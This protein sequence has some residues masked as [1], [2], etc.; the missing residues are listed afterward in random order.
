MK[1]FSLFILLISSPWSISSQNSGGGFHFSYNI[2]SQPNWASQFSNI[3]FSEDTLWVLGNAYTSESIPYTTVT[4]AK[5]DTFG[6]F[7]NQA[8]FY[9]LND[10]I[11]IT[12]GNDL[13]KL[14]NGNFAA[15][16][17]TFTGHQASLSIF[18]KLGYP[19]FHKLY[20][21]NGALSLDANRL[22][23]AQT[24]DIY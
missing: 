1:H 24:E 22:L 16:G 17:A 14:N 5:L 8:D 11:I 13:I 2:S 10:D 21:I 19:I 6:S 23:E 7:I 12:T 20:G 18:N 15:V 4:L 9:L 3:R